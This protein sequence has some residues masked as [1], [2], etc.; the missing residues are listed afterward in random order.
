MMITA[1]ELIKM[2]E[3]MA[4]ISGTTLKQE[5]ENFVTEGGW[6]LV[7]KNATYTEELHEE[8]E[9]AIM[10][11]SVMA[12]KKYL[13]ELITLAD[14]LDQKGLTAEANEVDKIVQSMNQPE[15]RYRDRDNLMWFQ[16]KA[17]REKEERMKTSKPGEEKPTKWLD[18][19]PKSAV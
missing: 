3:T 6:E 19:A 13:N 14:T 8:V 15:S 4:A 5:Y 10:G 9:K 7:I 12:G 17:K 18:E 1:Q 2:L 16:N 11:E